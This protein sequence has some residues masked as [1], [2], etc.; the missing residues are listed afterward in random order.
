[1]L[2]YNTETALNVIYGGQKTNVRKSEWYRTI[3]AGSGA[4]SAASEV[5]KKKHAV[6]RRFISHSFSTEAL[7]NSEPFIQE[8]IA[9]F[10]DLLAPKEG[11]KWSDKKDMAKW[12]TWLGFDIMGDLAFGK[13]FNCL[14][15]EENRY[16]P[17]AISSASVYMYWVSHSKQSSSCLSLHRAVPFSSWS[18]ATCANHEQQTHGIHWWQ[19]RD[20]QHSSRQLRC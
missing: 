13:R 14:E 3:D 4:F 19:I 18:V 11:K 12:C 15:S 7:R 10:C 17:E 8:N 6:R 1:M 20:R 16:I 5:D 2:S 9:R